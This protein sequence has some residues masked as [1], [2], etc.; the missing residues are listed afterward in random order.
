MAEEID[1][2][3]YIGKLKALQDEIDRLKFFCMIR[4]E[5]GKEDCRRA[6]ELV[7]ERDSLIEE[8]HSRMKKE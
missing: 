8:L 4:G 3:Y 7:K 6:Q 2:S 5:A 1:A